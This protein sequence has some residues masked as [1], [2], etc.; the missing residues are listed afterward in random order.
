MSISS[1]STI[2][3]QCLLSEKSECKCIIQ[4]INEFVNRTLTFTIIC[5]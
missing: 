3:S 2:K 5:Y 4:D 1:A